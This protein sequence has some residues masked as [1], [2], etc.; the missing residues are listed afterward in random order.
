MESEYSNFLVECL[1]ICVGISLA[2]MLMRVTLL[3]KVVFLMKS[4]NSAGH[5]PDLALTKYVFKFNY[6]RINSLFQSGP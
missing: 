6:V 5:L 3:P 2:E 1:S 4:Q